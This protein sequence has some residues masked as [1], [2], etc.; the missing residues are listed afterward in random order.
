MSEDRELRSLVEAALLGPAGERGSGLGDGRALDARALDARALDAA[1]RHG[2]L[3]DT[4]IGKAFFYQGDGAEAAYLLLDG[5]ARRTQYST[6]GKPVELPAL[7]RG[8]WL[9]LA[10]LALGGAHPC[11]V[12]AETDCRSLAF[13]GY[14]LAAMRAEGAVE[15]LLCRELAREVLGLH[16]FLADESP[17]ERILAFLLARRRL[18]AGTANS[19][20]AVTQERLARAVGLTR[21]TVNKKLALLEARGLVRARRGEIEVPDWEALSRASD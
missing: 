20:I 6:G 16:A 2:R 7:E 5:R 17:E 8:D 11:D 14:G 18:I 19:S 1:L 9:G 12:A 21:E 13:T 3:A 15:A 4:R 10:E